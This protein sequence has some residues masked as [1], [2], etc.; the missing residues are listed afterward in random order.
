MLEIAGITVFM[1]ALGYLGF[2]I[3]SLLLRDVAGVGALL[4]SLLGGYLLADFL[5]GFVHWAGDTVGTEKSPFV[6][7]HFVKP[8][9]M[10]HVDPKDITRHDF[11]ETNGNNCIVTVPVLL[12]LV[13]LLPDERGWGLLGA[14][15]VAF[16]TF[17]VFCTNQFH[18][19]AH[20]DN[21]P[22][23]ARVLQRWGL[24]L[25]P[26]HHDRHHA[27]PHDKYYCIT[28]GWLNPLLTK[29]RFFRIM[30]W[31]VALV[32]PKALYLAERQNPATPPPA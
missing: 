22:R 29:V 31:L 18:K 11:I 21:P 27:A 8:F 26:G 3:G 20:A 5:S 25:R 12:A 9:R 10:H 32:M 28:V 24:I 23:F 16:A 14:S 17:F 6:G 4:L 19:W 30:E 7:K 2:R 13:W 1:G 15:L